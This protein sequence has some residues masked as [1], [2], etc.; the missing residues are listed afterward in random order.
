[1]P[2]E[3]VR[4]TRAASDNRRVSSSSVRRGTGFGLMAAAAFGASAPIAKHLVGDVRPQ[5]LA[6]LLYAGAF[7]ALMLVRRRPT[8][9]ARLRRSDWPTLAGVTATG[10]VVAPV[11]MLLGLQRVTGVAGSLLLNLEAVLTVTLAV[12]VFGEHLGRRSWAGAATIVAGGG[13]LTIANSGGGR[14]DPVGVLLLVS[15]CTC[16]AV[17][18]NLTQRISDRDPFA[19]VRVKAAVSAAVN[20]VLAFALGAPLPSLG[21]IVVA[22]ALGSVAYGLSIVLDAYALRAVGAARESALFATG[23]FFGAVLAVPLLS[24]RLGWHEGSAALLMAGGVALMVFEHHVHSHTHQPVEHDH[25]HRHDDG[26][27]DHP[28]SDSESGVWHSHVHAHELLTHAHAHVSDSGH[29][30]QH[31]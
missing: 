31:A 4:R 5:L 13:V 16:W 9:E 29:R 30:H 19:I 12:T 1:M 8:A 23:P 27:H 3:R 26:H 7:L 10:G 2:R 18:N 15:A 25:R 14:V 22:M 21:L 28:H 24:E 11:L 6:G 20:V 17:D